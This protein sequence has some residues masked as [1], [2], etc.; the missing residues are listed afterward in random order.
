MTSLIGFI[1]VFGILVII[2]EFGH[3]YMAKRAGVLVREFAIGFGPKIF[4]H[5]GN[6]T[7]YTVRLLPLGGYVRMAGS[8]DDLI[9]IQPGMLINVEWDENQ[10]VQRIDLQK[11]TQNSNGIPL[12]VSEIDLNEALYI[13]GIVPTAENVQR[14][15]VSKTA[16]IIEEDGTELQVAPIE[17]QIQSATVMERVATYLA[18]PVMNFILS[19][20]TYI[21]IAFL[22]GG[23]INM[24]EA[25]IGEVLPDS[26]AAVAGL[27]AGDHVNAID[28]ENIET[29]TD[30]T[31]V[32]QQHPS[33]KLIFD[34]TRANGQPE[35]LEITPATEVAEDGTEYGMI[36]TAVSQDNSLWGKIKYGFTQTWV[37]GTGII[38]TL[39]QMLTGGLS[40][41]NLGGPI[42]IFNMT[43][44]AVEA[45][46]VPVLNFLAYL[47]VNLGVV[48]LFPIPALDGGRILMA[49]IEGIRGKPVSEKTETIITLI[50]AGIIF[51]IMI[52][53]T[54]NDISRFIR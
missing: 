35:T 38:M 6:E 3:Y 54:W 26:P 10:V 8:A 46:F 24:E 5:Q 28:G 31:S 33:E 42:A 27:Q 1:V 48:N 39:W 45:G 47:S 36:G 52:A 30:M 41:N 25:T 13:K 22:I 23:A 50:G 37:V 49:V 44:S 11:D 51:L 16:T 7:T 53:V 34:I 40:L 17:R 18:G 12:E 2:H 15:S 29:W 4:S 9:D 19:I 32:I 21:L 14:F 20:V 43:G